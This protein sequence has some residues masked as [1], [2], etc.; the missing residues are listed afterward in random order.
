MDFELCCREGAEQD[1]NFSLERTQIADLN[2]DKD[3]DSKLSV[4]AGPRNHL[5]DA[6][7]KRYQPGL[8]V[9]NQ[10]LRAGVLRV[11]PTKNGYSKVRCAGTNLSVIE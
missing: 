7:G 11:S 4:V 5:C 1:P 6:A 8:A 9:I 3:R 10:S 2:L